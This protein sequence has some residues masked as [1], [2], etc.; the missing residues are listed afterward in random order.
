MTKSVRQLK[1]AETFTRMNFFNQL[2]PDTLAIAT[3]ATWPNGR[4]EEIFLSTYRLSLF[5]LRLDILT[6]DQLGRLPPYCFH[7]C[8]ALLD[9]TFF[10]NG[11]I[12]MQMSNFPQW[13]SWVPAKLFSLVNTNIITSYKSMLSSGNWK[14]SKNQRY[15]KD[16]FMI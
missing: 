10:A 1:Y 12:E 15:V 8:L 16:A 13:S 2:W 3:N 9:T 14:D 5:F 7:W 4:N 11:M 6:F